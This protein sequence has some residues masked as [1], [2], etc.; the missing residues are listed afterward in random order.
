MQDCNPVPTPINSNHKLKAIETEDM[1]TD[2]MAYQQIIGSW[3]C[4]VTGTRP[5]LS[6][7]ITHLSQFNLSPFTLQVAAAKQVLRYLPGTNDRYLFHP[8][9]NQLKMTADMDAS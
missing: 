5:D 3:M 2:A 9:N 1:A 8:W 4:L 7:T 6:Y